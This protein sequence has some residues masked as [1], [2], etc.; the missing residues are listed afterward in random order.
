MDQ[1]R[2]KGWGGGEVKGGGRDRGPKG[3]WGG[4]AQR[5]EGEGEGDRWRGGEALLQY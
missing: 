4:C 2:V 3:M 5:G 1:R